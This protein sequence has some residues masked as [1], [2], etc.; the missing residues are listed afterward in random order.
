[1]S[2]IAAIALA[3]GRGLRARPLTLEGTGHIRSK[4]AVPFLGRPLV[5]WLVTAFRDQGVTDFHIAANG[6]ENR[7]QVRDA[8]GYGERFGVSVRYSRPGA[9][10]RNTGSGQATLSLIEEHDLRGHALVFPT[11]SLFELDLP[12]LVRDHVA[13]G[14]VVTVATA[15]RSAREVAGTYGTLVA[16]GTGRVERFVEK[17]SLAEVAAMAADPDRVPINA[18]LY[19][20]DCARLRA[21]ARGRDLAAMAGRGLDW[22][23]DLL[24]WLVA[25]GHRVISSPL[26]KVG[27]LGNPRAYLSTMAEALTGGYPS[28]RLPR[29]PVIHPSSLERRDAVSGMTLAEKLAGGL[30][31]VGPGAWIGRD[32]EVGP[33][34]A[35]RHSYVG[36]DADLH[37]WCRL[38]RVACLDGASV[39]PGARL[40]DAHVGV[41]ARVESSLRRP[42]VLDGFTALGHEARVAEGARLSGV[43]VYPGVAVAAGAPVPSG[44]V[45]DGPALDGPAL[46]GS[47]VNGECHSPASS[48]SSARS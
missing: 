38:E 44:A 12:G 43:L 20:V 22:G 46:D 39:G 29:G 9:D 4:A 34:V 15:Y 36:D 32:V 41:M 3:G 26:A 42:A 21:L 24:P 27:D 30:V 23:A 13:G 17:P 7:Y 6:R 31:H 14:A 48:R 45:L 37:P 19:L 28:L 40:S 10:R 11:D 16:D 47:A 18:G 5:E 33:G 8:L 25:H 1:M 2:S 35:V